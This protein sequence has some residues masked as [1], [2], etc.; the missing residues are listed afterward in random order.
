M[1]AMRLLRKCRCS[2]NSQIKPALQTIL[3]VAEAETW[4]EPRRLQVCHVPVGQ[5]AAI[6]RGLRR[7]ECTCREGSA[8]ATSTRLFPQS[9]RGD[10]AAVLGN[11]EQVITRRQRCD[12]DRSQNFA[13]S[14]G[15]PDRYL[16]VGQG[17][18]GSFP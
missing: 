9:G 2:C 12:G 1:V 13:I 3:E 14:F 4:P 10:K 18:G 5:R 8:D 7:A 15:E 17:L 16:G 11:V 6:A